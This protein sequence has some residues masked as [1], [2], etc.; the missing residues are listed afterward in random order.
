[1]AEVPGAVWNDRDL[2]VERF[3]PERIDGRYAVRTWL[4]F[5]DQGRHAIFYSRAPIVK[6]QNI[7]GYDRLAEVPAELRQVRRD[8]K[9]DFGKFDYTMVND[10]P[11]L[12][13]ANR[14]PT[15]GKFPRDRYLPIARSLADGIG[16]F[17]RSPR[18]VAPKRQHGMETAGCTAYR[19]TGSPASSSIP[20]SSRWGTI[21]ERRT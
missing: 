11:V 12:L 14:T 9:F 7:I 20:I 21:S 18:E 10:Q 2:V 1:M 19:P 17:L 15:I 16:V 6:A 13:D 3:L 4:F 8:L 5:G